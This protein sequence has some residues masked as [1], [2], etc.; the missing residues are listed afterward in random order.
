MASVI[1]TVSSFVAKVMLTDFLFACCK[2]LWPVL[3]IL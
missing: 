3:F 1:H 2:Q